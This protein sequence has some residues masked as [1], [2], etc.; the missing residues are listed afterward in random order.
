MKDPNKLCLSQGVLVEDRIPAEQWQGACVAFI[1][2]GVLTAFSLL[3]QE[4]SWLCP[5]VTVLWQ[6]SCASPT[7]PAMP[8]TGPWKTV[9]WPRLASFHWIMIAGSDVWMQSLTSGTA[10]CCTASVTGA[11]RDRSTAYA[12]S[13]LF[14]PA[15]QMVRWNNINTQVSS[16]TPQLKTTVKVHFPALYVIALEPYLLVKRIH[17]CS[18]WKA[19]K[20]DLVWDQPFKYTSNPKRQS[21]TETVRF[22]AVKNTSKWSCRSITEN[23]CDYDTYC[24]GIPK[25]SAAFFCGVLLLDLPLE[26]ACAAQLLTL[27]EA[28][29]SKWQH[30]PNSSWAKCNEGFTQ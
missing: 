23:E 27:T 6:S 16:P 5:A 2:T 20:T 30:R 7:P 10:L 1:L 22:S 11:W 8:H 19:E 12:F 9:P 3:D 13:G 24:H 28:E 21:Y 17:Y 25:C 15:R 29:Q 18:V 26:S 4:T 14:T